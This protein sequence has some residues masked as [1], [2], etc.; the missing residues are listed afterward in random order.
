[1]PE[2]EEAANQLVADAHEYTSLLLERGPGEYGFIHLTLQ[3]YLTAGASTQRGQRDVRPVIDILAPHI[4][5]DICH[6]CALLTVGYMGIVKQRDEVASE[7]LFEL[8][9]KPRGE[10]G[11][12]SVLAGEAVVDAWPGGVT[13]E[14][15]EAVIQVLQESFANDP[16]VKPMLRAAA[17]RAL[18]KLD[19]PRDS[20][21][22]IAKKEFLFVT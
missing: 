14:C 8:I 3:E 10:P 9:K 13:A 12:A 5:D 2:P 17:G 21:T 4:G 22:K 19:G 20:V 16:K 7:I 18:A 11:Q 1:M 6:E 15:K